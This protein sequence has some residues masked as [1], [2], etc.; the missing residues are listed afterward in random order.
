MRIAITSQLGKTKEL[1]E[2]CCMNYMWMMNHS[3]CATESAANFIKEVLIGLH[4]DLQPEDSDEAIKNLYD[5][6]ISTLLEGDRGGWQQIGAMVACGAIDVLILFC[7]DSN[8]YDQDIQS[9]IRL[10]TLYNIPIAI[11]KATANLVVSGMKKDD[12]NK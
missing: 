6:K 3:I 12:Y 4:K 10:A 7:E 9:L 2:W 1:T 11:N 8:V 5:S